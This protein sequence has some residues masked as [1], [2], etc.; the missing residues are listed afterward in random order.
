MN[1][2]E[3]KVRIEKLRDS[4]NHHRYQYHVLDRQEI[5]DAALDSLKHELYKLEQEFPELITTDSPTQRV[6]GKA[7][8]KYEKIKH[9]TRM[10]SIEDVFT[11]DEFVDWYHK[12]AEKIG[13]LKM[14]VFCMVK[15][16]GL[17]ISLRYEDGVL[18]TAA[19][20]GDGEIGEDI[21]SNIKTIEAVP[22]RLQ[23]IGS[24]FDVRN[25]SKGELEVRGEVFFP[26]KEFEKFNK[27]TEKEGKTA[28]AN[29]RNAAAGSIRQLDPR[30]TA[31]RGLSFF[32]WDLVT[33]IGQKTHDKEWEIL[34]ALGFK[35]NPEGGLVSSVPEVNEFWNKMQK[36]RGKLDYWIDGMVVRVNDNT[37]FERLGV[38]GKTPRGLI[39]WKFPAEEVTTVVEDVEWFVGRTGALTPVAVVKP[40]WLGGTT[41]KHASL[42][43]FDEIERL[44][45]KIG[46]TII[47]YKAG[48]IIPKIKG[49]LKEMRPKNAKNIQ[50]P[51]KCPVCGSPVKRSEGEVAVICSNRRC[52]AQ[53]R[54]RVLYAARAF[55]IDGFGPQTVSLLMDNNIVASPPDLFT[56]SIEDLLGLERFAEVSSN[57]LVEEIQAKK[58]IPLSRFI[59]ALGI[60]NVGEE[61]ARDL[62]THFGT[63]EKFIEASKEKLLTVPQIGEVVAESIVSFLSEDHNKKMI[64]EYLEN[65]VTIMPETAPKNN[66]PLSGQ[67][68]VLTGSLSSMSRDE[69]KEKLRALGA[70]PIESVSK[71]TTGVIVGE[72]PG[73]KYDKAKKLGVKILSEAEFIK[74]IKL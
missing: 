29:P 70:D 33:D 42:H 54:E 34:S 71:K 46:D 60:K 68:Y 45:V 59:I 10:L 36:R 26:V 5:S 14:E 39:A 20:R 55:G 1:K 50:L 11:P 69:A 37:A 51:D 58:K 16:D 63:L 62:A 9:K 72:E 19:T 32:A 41:V 57:K 13:K 47:I 44:G 18:K 65:G 66:L 53:D 8:E 43:N 67:T 64:E 73:S 40:T 15:L 49:V 21:T 74:L 7:L 28:F 31:G 24:K 52:Y 12:T 23:D 25:P 30:I 6:G 3:A 4:I 61:T 38:V 17:A 27:Q 2:A 56:F 22:L 35:T 48:D